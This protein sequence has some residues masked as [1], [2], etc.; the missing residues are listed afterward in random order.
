M[1]EIPYSSFL[2]KIESILNAAKKHNVGMRLMGAAAVKL[3]CPRFLYLHDLMER[4]LSDLD[5]MSLGKY[6][7][8]VK[9]LFK[10]LN[11]AI[12]QSL[13]YLTGG[14]R[15]LFYDPVDKIHVDIFF[16]RLEMCHAIDFRKRL[17][18][19]YPTISLADILLEKMQIVELSEKD[20]KDT[21]VLLR[22]HE[23]GDGERETINGEYIAGVLSDDWGFYYTVVRNLDKVK[24]RLS[25]Y[26]VLTVE[27][28]SCVEA[29]ISKILE[30][31][32][33]RPKSLKWTLRAKVGTKRKWYKEVGELRV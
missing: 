3:H 1:S 5:F 28:R 30:I 18:V 14:K 9:R 17:M 19:D 32:E 11:Y 22:E 24:G 25:R 20:V 10:E 15:Y 13:L 7:K 4:K 23:V 29:K 26:E 6:R 33:E 2:E 27:D 8:D 31:I 21:I 12:D 16:D